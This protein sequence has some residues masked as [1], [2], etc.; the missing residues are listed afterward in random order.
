MNYFLFG[1]IKYHTALQKKCSVKSFFFSN[2]PTLITTKMGNTSNM[3]I[4]LIHSMQ[5]ICMNVMSLIRC[6]AMLVTLKVDPVRTQ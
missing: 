2:D 4:H 6:T 5:L 3:S 1:V